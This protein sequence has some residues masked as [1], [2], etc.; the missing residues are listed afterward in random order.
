MIESPT[1]VTGPGIGGVGT[2]TT[3]AATVVVDARVATVDGDVDGEDA[4][5]AVDAGMPV[6]GGTVE[7]DACRPEWADRPVWAATVGEAAREVPRPTVRPSATPATSTAAD[8]TTP[9][10]RLTPPT[11]R[12]HHSLPVQGEIGTRCVLAARAWLT[13][14]RI[15]PAPE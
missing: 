14:H 9:T 11:P 2:A 1:A 13:S 8:T 7:V 15:R 10:C 12:M 3:G 6:D 4:P 5:G